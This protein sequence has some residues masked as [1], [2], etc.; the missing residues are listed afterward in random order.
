MQTRAVGV[1]T[2]GINRTNGRWVSVY[3]HVRSVA[4]Y[5]HIHPLGVCTAPKPFIPV[6]PHPACF[7]AEEEAAT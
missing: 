3:I 5:K 6:C 1:F 7:I 2:G 4:V